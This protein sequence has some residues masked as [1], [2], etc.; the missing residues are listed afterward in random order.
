M[1]A[2]MQRRRYELLEK[3]SGAN[4]LPPPPSPPSYPFFKKKIFFLVYG[5]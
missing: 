4:P 2:I 3:T 5:D 1:N